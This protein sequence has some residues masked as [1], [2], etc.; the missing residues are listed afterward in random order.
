ML[1]I[2]FNIQASAFVITYPVNNAV[3]GVGDGN[4]RALVWEKAFIKLAKV[5]EVLYNCCAAYLCLSSLPL[6][7]ICILGYNLFRLLAALN[8]VSVARFFQLHNQTL[9][10]IYEMKINVVAI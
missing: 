8:A 3:D 1:L 6:N 7:I 9:A 2:F 5:W 10:N 4:G